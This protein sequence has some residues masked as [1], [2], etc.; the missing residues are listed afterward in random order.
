MF[1]PHT[2]DRFA[3]FSTSLLPAYNS[4]F[5][6]PGSC[7]VDALGQTDWAHHNNFVNPPFRLISRVL[8]VVEAQQADATLIAPLWP[9]QPWMSRLRQLC[10]APPLRLPPV[11]RTCVPLLPFQQVEPHRNLRWTLYAWR[12]SGACS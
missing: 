3:S 7:G 9:G 11:S 4:R 2:I 8:D 10:V 1:G 6:D 5:C 12:F